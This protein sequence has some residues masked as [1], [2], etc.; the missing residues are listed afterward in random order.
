MTKSLVRGGQINLH[1][2]RMFK[3]VVMVGLGLSLLLGMGVSAARWHRTVPL[4]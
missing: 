2:L 4:I 3:Q 1:N